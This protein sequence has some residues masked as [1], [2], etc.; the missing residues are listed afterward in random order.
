MT[1]APAVVSRVF[2][3]W[4]VKHDKGNVPDL[5]LVDVEIFS[6]GFY[7]NGLLSRSSRREAMKISPGDEVGGLQ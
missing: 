7:R 3:V 5:Y 6:D 1:A 4:E 2:G